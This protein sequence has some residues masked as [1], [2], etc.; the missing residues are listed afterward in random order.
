MP[1]MSTGSPGTE[2]TWGYLI[3]VVACFGYTR[4]LNPQS[5][6]QDRAL[7]SGSTSGHDTTMWWNHQQSNQDISDSRAYTLIIPVLS[8]QP[9]V[10]GTLAILDLR[11]VE[12]EK[13]NILLPLQVI[14]K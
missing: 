3:K 6:G 7:F 2:A 11:E 9:H 1:V 14:R 12:E 10:L 4:S 8:Q 13:E 5:P